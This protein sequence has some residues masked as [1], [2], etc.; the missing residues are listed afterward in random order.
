MLLALEK[1]SESVRVNIYS[2]LVHL[3]IE[4]LIYAKNTTVVKK[5]T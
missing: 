4:Q 1:I 3:F 2:F 5:E